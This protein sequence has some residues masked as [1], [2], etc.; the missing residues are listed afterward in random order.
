M[1]RLGIDLGGTNLKAGITDES[2]RLILKGSVKTR[3]RRAEA[4]VNDSAELCFDVLSK[5]GVK[6][7]DIEGVGALVP[8]SFDPETGLVDFCPALDLAGVPFAAL[9]GERLGKKV[10]VENDAN[11]AALAEYTLGSGKGA[12]SL[13]AVT[14]GTG[15]GG[16]IIIDGRI[17]SGCNHASGEI[18]HMV[19][20]Q[21]GEKCSCG[22]LGCFEAYASATALK[23]QT[24]EMML[25]RPGSLMWGESGGLEN[26][27]GAT[28]FVAAG[29]GDAA[30]KEVLERYF[31]H[32]ACGLTNII[33]IFQPEVLCI[34]GGLSNEGEGLIN[35]LRAIIDREDFA[36]HGKKRTKLVLAT[37]GNDAGIIGASLLPGLN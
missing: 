7:E 36:H 17:Y 12:K 9:L 21:G 3:D 11:L 26:V 20:L 31:G 1:L 35:P 16:G 27:T 34:G 10:Y 24:K 19:I 14:L 37:L 6:I 22:R 13:V 30:A 8:G 25:L 5:A 32:L 15:I 18:G 23:R 4:V 2:G 28:A 29:K 33:N